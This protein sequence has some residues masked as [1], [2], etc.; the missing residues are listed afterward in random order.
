[1]AGGV[2]W[3]WGGGGIGSGWA[4]SRLGSRWGSGA[5]SPPWSGRWPF[6][7]CSQEYHS[8]IITGLGLDTCNHAVIATTSAHPSLPLVCHQLRM[9]VHV[10]LDRASEH[11]QNHGERIL[12]E[13]LYCA[14]CKEEA[15]KLGPEKKRV[16]VHELN[17]VGVQAPDEQPVRFHEVQPSAEKSHWRAGIDCPPQVTTWKSGSPCC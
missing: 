16:L 10:S 2:R 15:A 11:S 5:T 8:R 9:E 3:V 4:G 7:H 6:I 14:A 12:R 1:M 13:T 17:F